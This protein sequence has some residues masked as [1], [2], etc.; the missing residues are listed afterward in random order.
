[1]IAPDFF[2]SNSRG[3]HQRP[4]PPIVVQEVK[5]DYIAGLTPADAVAFQRVVYHPKCLDE[6]CTN[7]N[8]TVTLYR[9]GSFNLLSLGDVEDPQLSARFRRDKFISSETDV[10]ILAHH[11]ADNEFT[12]EKFLQRVEP[13]LAICTADYDNKHDHPREE[14]RDMLYEQDIRLMTTK[15]GDVLV[16]SIGAHTGAY[17]AINYKARSQEVSSMERYVSKKSELLKHNADTIR[18]RYAPTPPYRRILR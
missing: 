15:T 3:A 16:R 17:E 14:I 2:M 13:H 18:Q 4:A 7:S 5:P 1:M 8:S 10:M 11:G 9:E 6:S 12:N